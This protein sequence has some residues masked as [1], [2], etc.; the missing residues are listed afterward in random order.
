MC[1]STQILK[2][3]PLLLMMVLA[4]PWRTRSVCVV[5]EGQQQGGTVCTTGAL[6]R[7]DTS[8]SG[9]ADGSG[10]VNVLGKMEKEE[11]A[12]IWRSSLDVWSFCM[13]WK[14]GWMRIYGWGSREANE[15]H[16]VVGV[17]YRLPDQVS[18]IQLIGG[19]YIPEI[20]ATTLKGKGIQESQQVCKQ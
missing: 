6:G 10:T 17:C 2:L 3:L 11:L 19:S 4:E 12:C 16:P 18:T 9:G 7:V 1:V 8:S 20:P 13:G 5:T 14:T 15:G